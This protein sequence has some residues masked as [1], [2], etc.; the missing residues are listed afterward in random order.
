MLLLL[1]TFD[2]TIDNLYEPLA[3]LGEEEYSIADMA[4]AIATE[5][6]NR[7]V[8]FDR[9]KADGQFRKSMGNETLKS[10]LPNFE[11]TTL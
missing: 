10:L 6:S 9:S 5:F 3:L 2:S 11:F 8:V 4:H 1:V 7:E